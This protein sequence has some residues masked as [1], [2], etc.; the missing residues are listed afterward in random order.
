MG[1]WADG[2]GTAACVELSR[3]LI[4]KKPASVTSGPDLNGLLLVHDKIIPNASL[5]LKLVDICYD[6]YVNSMFS[7]SYFP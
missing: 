2:I 4:L 5:K 7:L 3:R 6:E 1:R